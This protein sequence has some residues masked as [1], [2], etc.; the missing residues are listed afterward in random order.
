MDFALKKPWKSRFIT[1]WDGFPSPNPPTNSAEEA[2]HPR[3]PSVGAF[4]CRE[5]PDYSELWLGPA[6]IRWNWS[7]PGHV[8]YP[9]PPCKSLPLPSA[10]A[11]RR[12]ERPDYSGLWLGPAG[13]RKD[14]AW[15]GHD[16]D[17]ALLCKRLR[18]PS[19]A[20]YRRREWQDC[21]AP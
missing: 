17:L 8:G 6:D 2:K 3:P 21:L 16:E 9:G 7:Q 10:A 15:L 1:T 20:A 19:T 11:F 13:R 18:L 12:R 4:R 5:C 14:W